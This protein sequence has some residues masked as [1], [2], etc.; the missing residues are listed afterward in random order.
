MKLRTIVAG[1]RQHKYFAIPRAAGDDESIVITTPAVDLYGDRVMPEGADLSGYLPNPIVLWLH[2][3][4]GWTE[5]AG[6]PIGTARSLEIVPGVGIKCTGIDWLVGDAFADRIR[7]AWD[8]EKIRAASIG[9][10]PLDDGWKPNEYGGYDFTK[11]RL[12]EFSLVPIP[13]NPEAIR[14]GLALAKSLGADL[15]RDPAA[16]APRA[17]AKAGRV[18]SAK[19][20]GR[21]KAAQEAIGAVIAEQEAEEETEGARAPEVRTAA[22]RAIREVCQAL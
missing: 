10:L 19:N 14:G 7:N 2:D 4:Y 3:A 22:E 9:F 17:R 5:S 18:L 1:Q 12:L 20:L 11:W 15:V 13:A 21:L 16:P 6:V 8:Q